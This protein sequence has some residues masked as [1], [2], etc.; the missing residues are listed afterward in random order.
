[1]NMVS[2]ARATLWIVGTSVSIEDG[3]YVTRLHQRIQQTGMSLRN[4]SVGDQTSVMGYMR[5]LDHREEIAPGDV[6]VWEYSLLDTLL[7]ESRF[8]ADDVHCARRLAWRCVLERGAQVI[9][10]LTAPKKYLARRSACERKIAHDAQV[11]G[12]P[13]VDTR[14][15]VAE[16]GIRDANEHYRDDRHPAL[17]SP[18]IDAMVDAVLGHTRAPVRVAEKTLS[19]WSRKNI[20]RRWDWLSARMLAEMAGVP[21][22]QFQ[23]SLL[24]INVAP[25]AA[26]ATVP[27][28]PMLRIVSIGCISTHESGGLWCGHPRCRPMS[29]R[30][31]ADLAYAFLLRTTGTP[32]SHGVSRIVLAPEHAY[33]RGVWCAYGQELCD[34]SGTVAVFGIL[35][36]TQADLRSALQTK[37]HFHWRR[38][39]AAPRIYLQWLRGGSQT[40][41]S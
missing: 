15:L 40:R 2:T 13:C 26:N 16:L 1:M 39:R 20:R 41:R 34:S 3:G 38:L 9:V 30:L 37:L 31:P 17:N 12:L 27:M 11:L 33:R 14:D 32:C 4:L 10:L 6:V 5:V 23:N 8:V 21:V 24:S 22:Q 19:D 25:L 28:P 36:E 29:T 35:Y 7:T 18:V